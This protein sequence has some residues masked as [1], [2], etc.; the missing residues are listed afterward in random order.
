MITFEFN[1]RSTSGQSL[2]ALFLIVVP[3][4][5]VMAALLS[6]W[7]AWWIQDI[8]ADY[9][10][11]LLGDAPSILTLAIFGIAVRAMFPSPSKSEEG[12]QQDLLTLFIAPPFAWAFAQLVAWVA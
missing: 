7:G 10:V 3:V 11:P 4:L 5:F 8:W 12:N 1:K 2:L 6:L 9:L